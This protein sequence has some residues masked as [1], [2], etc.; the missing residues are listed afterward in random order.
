MY[1]NRPT[2]CLL[3]LFYPIKK[4][5]SCNCIDICKYTPTPPPPAAAINLFTNKKKKP[6]QIEPVK[7]IY[8][9]S[10]NDVFEE[11]VA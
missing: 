5:I 7:A 2:H 8:R 3:K 9:Y 1:F 6:N 4:E 10:N 11:L